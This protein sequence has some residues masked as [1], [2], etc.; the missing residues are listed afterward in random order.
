MAFDP[1]GVRA[2]PRT[3]GKEVNNVDIKCVISCRISSSDN[4]VG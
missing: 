4:F 2:K 1:W 3:S